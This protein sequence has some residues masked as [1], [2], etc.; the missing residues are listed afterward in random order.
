MENNE[1]PNNLSDEEV[2]DLFIEGIMAEKGVEAPTEEIK[3]DL[4][5]DLKNQ[6]LQQIDRSLVAE[7]PDDKLEEL[8]NKAAADGELNPEEVAKAIEEANL[9][10]TEI[11]AG[12]MQRFREIYLGK[13]PESESQPSNEEKVEA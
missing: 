3:N 10:V 1:V 8:N 4:K 12:T 6:L 2:I 13:T 11:T 5:N 7:L 9:D